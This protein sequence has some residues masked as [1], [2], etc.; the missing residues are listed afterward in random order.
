MRINRR[1]FNYKLGLLRLFT[2]L[3]FSLLISI[4]AMAHSGTH[5]ITLVYSGNLDGELEPCGCS[6]GSDKGGIKRWVQKIDE[7][8]IEDP[9]LYLIS[10]GGLITSEVPQDKVKAEYIL[11]GLE[12]LDY[13]AV[14]VQWK[15]LAYGTDFISHSKLPFVLTNGISGEFLKK[16]LINKN[17]A[18]ISFF[19]WLDPVSDPQIGM[20]A[21]LANTDTLS[22]SEALLAAKKNKQ[23]TL[24]STTLSLTEAQKQLPLENVDLLIIKAKYE[25]Y[26]D[27][28]SV[29]DMLVLTPGSRGM[30]LA[31]LKLD[32]NNDGDIKKW[33]QTVIPLPPEVKDAE[34]MLAWYADYNAKVKA[35]YEKSVA[36]RKNHASGNS[37]FAGELV[38]ETCHKKEHDKWFDSRHAEAFYALQDVNKA[39]DPACI[40]CHVVGFETEGG[41][42][43]PS[44][45]ESLM[46]V[47]CENCHGA[48]KAH[49]DSGGQQKT[50]NTDW[51]AEQMCQQ[52]HVQKHSPDFKFD[53]YWS[54]I[55]HGKKD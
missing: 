9:D 18:K 29:N 31:K 53:D 14:A 20:Q 45:T 23:T 15:D 3:L 55:S 38:C 11:K 49:A 8:R 47:Q 37:Q 13:D 35:D 2:T 16:S 50:A 43:D 34:R 10:A 39:F 33:Q 54:K 42:I 24:L 5:A 36:I 46:H 32:I 26:G 48:A 12:H 22:L 1:L 27:V 21:P 19:N 44:I 7:L 28:Q 41:F 51:S 4:Q 40:K 30:R 25:H 6:E 17:H 52:C